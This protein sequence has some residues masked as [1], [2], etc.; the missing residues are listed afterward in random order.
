MG[1]NSNLS[2][3]KIGRKA[4]D[5]FEGLESFSAHQTITS[6]PTYVEADVT[7]KKPNKV[8]VE[9]TEYQDP[10]EELE[11]DI[12]GGAEFTSE[13]LQ[14]SLILY[15]GKKTWL[16]NRTQN[17]AIQKRGRSVPSPFGK[18]EVLAEVGFLSNLTGDFLLKQQGKGKVND[19]AVHRLNLKPKVSRR[20][21]FLKEEVFVLQKASLALDA[22]TGFPLKITYHPGPQ[23]VYSSPREGRQ[24]TVEYTD[25]QFN[26]TSDEQYE[27][28]PTRVGKVFTEKPVPT[29]ELNEEIDL[30]LDISAFEEAG[31]EPLTPT[32]SLFVNDTDDKLYFSLTLVDSDAS[33][34]Q[35]PSTI[36][37]LAGNHLSP[38]MKRHRSFV[39]D[40][41]SEI[42][43]DNVEGQIADRAKQ[44]REKLP[45]G[46]DQDMYEIGWEKQGEFYYLL[47]QGIDRS[48]MIEIAEQ[49]Y[50]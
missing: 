16:H 18:T 35:V 45:E 34:E 15:N 3:R 6:G 25:L 22:E 30:S 29:E 12:S 1:A 41:G 7:Y 36:Q 27:F 4:M 43:I 32:T 9:Y 28:D 11:I 26:T 47:G 37:C 14:N 17:T 31:L 2:E 49:A 5:C 10:L 42:S 8:T 46:L 44:I 38:E 48:K 33:G 39:F 40:K 21:Y 24:I 23:S 20:S 19:K 50:Q 13:E